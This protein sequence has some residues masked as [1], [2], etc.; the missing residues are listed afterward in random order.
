MTDD[1]DVTQNARDVVTELAEA[2]DDQARAALAA[3][4]AKPEGEQRTTVIK[5]AEARIAE[6]APVT[7]TEGS[8]VE[9]EPSGAWAQL[10]DGDGEPVLVDGNPV[11]AGLVP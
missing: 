4:Q 7:E 1:I 5:A 11:D 10:L 9:G 8:V 3:E 2:D 6:L